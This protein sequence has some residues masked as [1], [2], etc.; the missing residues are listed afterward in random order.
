MLREGGREAPSSP[1]GGGLV[2]LR[3]VP[4]PELAFDRVSTSRIQEARCRDRDVCPGVAILGEAC[5]ACT[6]VDN[7]RKK[8]TDSMWIAFT[9]EG[10]PLS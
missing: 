5:I 8:L 4:W 7:S 2:T 3:G 6:Y 1:G 10:C 9:R